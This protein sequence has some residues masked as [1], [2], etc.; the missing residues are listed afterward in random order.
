MQQ[1]RVSRWLRWPLGPAA[2]AAG[3]A[4]AIVGCASGI[5][6]GREISN[7]QPTSA[8]ARS[9]WHPA[10]ATRAAPWRVVTPSGPGRLRPV[11]GGSPAAGPIER[12]AE[13]APQQP[14]RNEVPDQQPQR[15]DTRDTASEPP[16]SPA[17]V[18][19][20]LARQLATAAPGSMLTV[21]VHGTSL[22]AARQAVEATGMQPITAFERIGVIAA[23][24][25]PAQIRA[26]RTEPGVIF[27]E[28]NPPTE[29]FA[30]R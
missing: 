22:T 6:P 3:A 30:G 16:Q 5:A 7:E 17:P 4:V 23:R 1:R 25:T 15:A 10:S 20:Y 21:L 13:A 26:A 11:A 9:T 29:F 19:D 14:T 28:G 24:A 27:L 12:E 18:G 2:L 8:P